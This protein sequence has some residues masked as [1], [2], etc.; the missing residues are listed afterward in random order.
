MCEVG[1]GAEDTGKKD[2]HSFRHTVGDFLKQSG[3]EP[4]VISELLGHSVDSIT[5][6]RYGK[7]YSPRVLK[8]QAVDKLDYVIDLSHLKK[9][10][11]VVKS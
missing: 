6:S 5:L 11:F 8:K 4:S 2:F 9:S 3:V 7:R 10:R 1:G